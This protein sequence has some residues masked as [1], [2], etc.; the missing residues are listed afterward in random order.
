MKKK[1]AIW[2]C[3]GITCLFLLYMSIV[4]IKGFLTVLE[5]VFFDDFNAFIRS[6]HF[7]VLILPILCLVCFI[8]IIVSIVIIV[9]IKDDTSES[10]KL[11]YNEYKEQIKLKL[12][13]KQELNKQIKLNKLKRKINDLEKDE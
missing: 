10:F 4:S 3:L 12:K 7:F 11:Y 9:L 6:P 5:L 13:K 1:I 8:L 2:C